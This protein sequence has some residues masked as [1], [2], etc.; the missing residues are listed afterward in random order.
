MQPPPKLNL[1][2]AFPYADTANVA[3]LA[4]NKDRIRLLVDSGAFTAWK[5][6]KPVEM[7][8]YCRFIETC[9]ATPWRYFML[10]VIGDPHAT[11]ANYDTML[12]RGL[13]PIPIFT[14]GE[15]PRALDDYFATS[16]V[17]GL[18]G[19]AGS[20]QR[21][22]PYLKWLWPQLAGRQVHI[23]GFSRFDWLKILQPYTCDSSTW[24]QAGRFGSADVYLGNGRFKTLR[25][26]HFLERP[27][28]EL[29]DAI[30]RLGLD[31]YALQKN[32]AWHGGASLA[33]WLGASSWVAAQMDIS[34][35][36]PTSL[37]LA[38]AGSLAGQILLGA[39]E[40]QTTGQWGE[41]APER[42]WRTS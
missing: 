20:G 33:R 11:R 16:E 6:G 1:L 2:T 32:E 41:Y 12:G 7:D 36:L 17:V 14:R 40:R 27:A 9:P 23:L 28:P 10:D 21:P 22:A 13:N 39:H 37:F 25:K 42:V 26:H 34:R 3:F 5:L 4:R 8:D 24:E 18:G 35:N 19:L 31:P 29:M 38:Y 30:A 15:D